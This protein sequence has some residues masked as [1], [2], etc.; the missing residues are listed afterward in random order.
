MAAR[1]WAAKEAVAKTTGAGLPLRPA[2]LATR[3]APDA[4]EA[5][6]LDGLGSVALRVQSDGSALEAWTD[7]IG[8]VAY[9]A[10]QGTGGDRP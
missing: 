4:T 3:L 7:I 8:P 9:A 2:E 5:I 10:C 6:D 1:L